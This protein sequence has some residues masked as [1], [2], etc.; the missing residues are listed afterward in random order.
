MDWL[1]ILFYVG[2]SS[3]TRHLLYKRFYSGNG[4]WIVKEID[5]IFVKGLV[6]LEHG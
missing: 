3:G 6:H 4:N 5:W 1:F 2:G